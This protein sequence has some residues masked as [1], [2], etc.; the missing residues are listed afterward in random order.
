MLTLLIIIYLVCGVAWIL[1][2][3]IKEETFDL[4]G[5]FVSNWVIY[6]WALFFW[7][8]WICL[9]VKDRIVTKYAN[10]KNNKD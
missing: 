9:R 3:I 4:G 2:G 6:P 10:S 8:V 1:Y 5:G 7:W